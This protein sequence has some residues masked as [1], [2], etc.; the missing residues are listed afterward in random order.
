M[1]E[2]ALPAWERV[3]RGPAPLDFQKLTAACAKNNIDILGPLPE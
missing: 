2:M 1:L 3:L